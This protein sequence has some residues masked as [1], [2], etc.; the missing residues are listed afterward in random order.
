MKKPIVRQ[1]NAPPEVLEDIRQLILQARNRMARAV[2]SQIVNAYWNIGRLIVEEEQKGSATASYGEQLIERLAERLTK[3]FGNGFSTTNLMYFR[4]FY[5]KFQIPH[6][7][8]EDFTEPIPHAPREVFPELL[9]TV[10]GE[11][12]WTHYR[13]LLKVKDHDAIEFYME[14]AISQ[15]W[16]TR[17]LER[18][19]N[20][21]YYERLLG[22]GNKN[23]VKNEAVQKTQTLMDTPAGLIKNPY[24]FEFLGLGTDGANLEKEVEN[25]LIGNLSKFLIELGK[26]F[27]FVARQ[28]HLRTETKDF[29]IDLV[30]YNYILKCFVLVDLKIGELSHQDIGQM[31]MYV[32]LY[33]EKYR[34]ES[35]NPTIGIILCTEKDETIVKYSVLKENKRLFASRYQLYL[36]TEEELKQELSRWEQTN[37][38]R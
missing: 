19:I 26:G 38:L 20:S 9:H 17:A 15:D 34:G 35:D 14:E 30:F 22:Q 23:E 4:Q 32:R 33:E 18:Q 28:K 8:R 29:F 16:S 36:P 12:T 37:P 5:L 25:A 27:A 6:A 3:E 24:V 7:V 21:L 11:L 2:N 10:R 1:V 13:L 31:D